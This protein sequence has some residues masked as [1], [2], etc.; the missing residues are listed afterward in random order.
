MYLEE[1]IDRLIAAVDYPRYDKGAMIS[2]CGRYRYSLMRRWEGDGSRDL[3]FVM[4]NP[5]TADANKDDNTIR[6]IV[7]FAKRFGYGGI[8]VANLFAYRATNPST[9]LA[10][11]DPQG[12]DN[13]YTWQVLIDAA[14]GR[15]SPIVCA[16][17]ASLI[18]VEAGKKFIE[19]AELRRAKLTCLELTQE[20]HPKHPL[21]IKDET[22]LQPYG[23][24][25]DL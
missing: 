2:E 6:K 12:P 1:A 11:D 19:F 7:K 20:G 3:T 5:S 21:Y 24:D 8:L 13:I 23:T 17:G 9:L 16:W 4:L 14:T 15:G 22:D 25:T 18:A 10:V